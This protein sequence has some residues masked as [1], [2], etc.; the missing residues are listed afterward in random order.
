[1]L[2][3]ATGLLG[4]VLD[5]DGQRALITFALVP[6]TATADS[7]EEKTLTAPSITLQ[8]AGNSLAYAWGLPADVDLAA[9]DALTAS[10][11]VVS[12]ATDGVYAVQL[13]IIERDADGAIV[14]VY[15]DVIELDV[16]SP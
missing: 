7:G 16:L 10:S 5:A 4:G 2:N 13:S 9:G 15:G 1:M 8:A 12:S 11:I 14:R 3:G 6:R